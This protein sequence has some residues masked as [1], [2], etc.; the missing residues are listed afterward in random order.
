MIKP[1]PFSTTQV[2][3][4]RLSQARDSST[5]RPLREK[6]IMSR[7]TDAVTIAAMVEMSRI[8]LYTS[9]MISFALVHTS[10]AAK[11]GWVNIIAIVQ[12]RNNVYRILQ[13]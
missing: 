13:G 10:V 1:K 2:M 7:A 6:F 12:T 3:T 8:W 9:F 11:A 4:M 5:V